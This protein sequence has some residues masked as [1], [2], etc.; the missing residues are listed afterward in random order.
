[1]I[2]KIFKKI[3]TEEPKI[4]NQK[5]SKTLFLEK[6]Q[7]KS[8]H[9]KIKTSQVVKNQKNQEKKAKLLLQKNPP[10]NQEKNQ[11]ADQ[12]N[13]ENELDVK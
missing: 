13:Q 3:K 6:T 10:K 8:R 7:Q 11:G 9:Q 4:R 2:Q 5:Y 1:V 12:K